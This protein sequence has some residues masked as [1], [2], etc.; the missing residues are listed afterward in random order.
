MDTNISTKEI[1]GAAIKIHKC[2]GPGLL[3]SAYEECLCYELE[4]KG[5]NIGR[6]KP[7]RVVYKDI[8]LNYG[9]RIYI[10]VDD[11]V[12]LELKLVEILAPVH[13]AQILICMKFVHKKIGLL[14]NFNV[15]ILKNG[16][17]RYII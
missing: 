1:I 14:I 12:V 15:T 9:Y 8:M 13:E 7:F 2:L 4:N 10:L 11:A 17:T 6:Q 16:L 5:F 3:E